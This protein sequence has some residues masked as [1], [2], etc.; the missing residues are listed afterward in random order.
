VALLPFGGAVAGA[1]PD[2]RLSID[3][4]SKTCYISPVKTG[5]M[6]IFTPY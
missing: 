2:D 6:K 4:F 5:F 1:T 3:K